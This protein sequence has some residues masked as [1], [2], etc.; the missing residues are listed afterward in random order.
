MNRS[1]LP[2]GSR[3]QD[4]PPRGPGT[5]RLGVDNLAIHVGGKPL[6]SGVSFEIQAGRALTLIGESGGGKSLLA[7][8]IMGTLPGTLQASGRIL[9][10]GAVHHAD[11][12][13]SRRRLWGR[14]LALLPQEPWSALDPTMRVGAQLSESYRFVL[15][16]EH[17]TAHQR[18]S[19]ELSAIGLGRAF[20]AWPATLSGGMAQRAVFAMTR[21]GGASMLI[22][23]EP[24][25]GLDHRWRNQ[26]VQRLQQALAQSCA[27]LTITHDIEVARRLGG[28]IAVML[29]GSIVEYGAAEDVLERPRH[30]FTRALLAAQ[31]AAWTPRPT[32][33]K[34]A[35]EVIAG[36]GLCKRFGE[37]ALFRDLDLTLAA[38]DAIAITGPSGTGKSTL[39][40]VLL[41]L[42]TPDSGTVR[43]P[44]GVPATRYQK[45]YQD[46]GSAF[47]PRIAIGRSI[48]DLCALHRLDRARIPGLMVRLGLSDALLAR[49]PTAVSGGELQRFALLRAL[50]MQPV[51][52]FADEP[53][54]RLDPVTQQETMALML[55]T[56]AENQ[57]ALMLVTHD[58]DIARHVA[59][60]QIV[61]G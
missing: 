53:T 35:N 25:K 31:P 5:T 6:L 47:A 1:D 36:V 19:A 22:A 18:A 39:G 3:L 37:Q 9:F 48:L 28:D 43:R 50:L 42:L 27:V 20:R 40:N 51:F 17:D 23:D 30:D 8:A 10:D 14:K 4:F 41:G 56:M 57:C 44:A 11:D 24:T 15:G 12:P 26:I 52:L 60:R 13:D 21:A 45:L 33:A 49:Q 32:P 7:H 38:G 54:S 59:Q 29:G 34:G 55:E 2:G 58:G 16:E 46:P 61:F